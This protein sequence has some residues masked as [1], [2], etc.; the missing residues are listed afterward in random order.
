[1]I[2]H[3]VQFLSKKADDGWH[4]NAGEPLCVTL[5]I[6]ER[7][8]RRSVEALTKAGILEVQRRQFNHAIRPLVMPE[9]LAE[10]IAQ[11]GQSGRSQHAK[12]AGTT[13]QSG[14]SQSAKVAGTTCQNGR[15]QSAKVAGTTCQS[16]RNALSSTPVRELNK[17][18]DKLKDELE[19]SPHVPPGETVAQLAPASKLKL[20]LASLDSIFEEALRRTQLP[21]DHKQYQS[22]LPFRRSDLEIVDPDQW[23]QINEKRE[24]MKGSSWTYNGARNMLTKVVRCATKGFQNQPPLTHEEIFLGLEHYLQSTG[25]AVNEDW[26]YERGRGRTQPIA[27]STKLSAA[28]IRKQR[29]LRIANES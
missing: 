2:Y 15:S 7:T 24:N 8:Y 17:L 12:M 11:T 10:F 23:R 25:I 20:N 18:E 26:L 9:N 14:R 4:V 19:E 28:D 5:D 22:T 3:R 21:D 13:C 16:G 27:D 6:A 29:H 1:M